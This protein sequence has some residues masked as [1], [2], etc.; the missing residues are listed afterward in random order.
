VLDDRFCRAE[1]VRSDAHHDRVA[2]A[3]D[4]GSVGKDV[5]PPLEDEGDDAQRCP[6]RFDPPNLVVDGAEH[7]VAAEGRTRPAAQPGDHVVEHP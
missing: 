2:G 6:S 4:T 7:L 1:G 3:H 5:G